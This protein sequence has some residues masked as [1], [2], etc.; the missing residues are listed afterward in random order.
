MVPRLFEA[1]SFGDTRGVDCPECDE[2]LDISATQPQFLR[3]CDCLLIFVV[4]D[5]GLQGLS[6]QAPPGLDP[7]DFFASMTAN[8]GF[9]DDDE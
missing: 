1:E 2:P 5:S 3:C 4:K 8:L 7:E 6:V 9:E